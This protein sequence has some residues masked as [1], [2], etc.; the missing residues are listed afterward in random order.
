MARRF[1]GGAAGQAPL[2]IQLSTT[3]SGD[4]SVAVVVGYRATGESATGSASRPILS[5]P[6]TLGVGSTTVS[7]LRSV[8]VGVTPACNLL[9][10]FSSA[11]SLPGVNEGTFNLPIRISWL[12]NP[13]DGI[14]VGSQGAEAGLL[15]YASA[16]GGHTWTGSIVWEEA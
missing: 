7:N 3:A 11:P 13:E 10:S 6:S 2:Q 9:A 12:T 1:E 5:R 16:S 15:L 14:V 4:G 8:P